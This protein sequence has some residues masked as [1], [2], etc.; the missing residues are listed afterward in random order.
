MILTLRVKWSRE[1]E[2]VL[3]VDYSL[4][5]VGDELLYHLEYTERSRIMVNAYI[6][7][8]LLCLE[9]LKL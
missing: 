1:L 4:E 6:Q 2:S 3:S 9:A 7:D 5:K 8:L